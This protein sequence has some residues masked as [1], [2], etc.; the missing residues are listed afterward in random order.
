MH[1][2]RFSF[3]RLRSRLAAKIGRYRYG[4]SALD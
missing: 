2:A 1:F 3:D 4:I